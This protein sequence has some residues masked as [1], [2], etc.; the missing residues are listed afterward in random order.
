MLNSVKIPND[1]KNNLFSEKIEVSNT[2]FSLSES[3]CINNLEDNE[4]NENSKFDQK[5]TKGLNINTKQNSNYKK[6]KDINRYSKKIFANDIPNLF[7]KYS[8]L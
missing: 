4:K 7:K 3:K 5:A 2:I 8:V 6:N 1:K